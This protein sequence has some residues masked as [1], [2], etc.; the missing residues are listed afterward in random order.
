MKSTLQDTTVTARK[1]L[2][3]TVH[4]GWIVTARKSQERR[5]VQLLLVAIYI[6]E[7][8][9]LHLR[10]RTQEEAYP[11]YTT[12]SPW[13]DMKDFPCS[14]DEARYFDPE[15]LGGEEN[16]HAAAAHTIDR[17]AAQ[18]MGDAYTEALGQHGRKCGNFHT[19]YADPVPPLLAVGNFT[20]PPSLE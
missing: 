17:W 10:H 7:M 14:G 15:K 11:S 12:Q 16:A 6:P 18:K 20:P 4:I 9:V 2:R 19:F 3:Q 5:N 8:G 13:Q 1:M